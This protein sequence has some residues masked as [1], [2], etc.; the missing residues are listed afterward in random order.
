MWRVPGQAILGAGGIWV[1]S[2]SFY[3]LYFQSGALEEARFGLVWEVVQIFNNRHLWRPFPI[4]KSLI[5]VS[6]VG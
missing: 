5:P 3:S 2:L 4:K 6:L 1:M